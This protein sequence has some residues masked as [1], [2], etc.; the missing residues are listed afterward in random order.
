[1]VKAVI[2]LQILTSSAIGQVTLSEILSN[3]P[4]GR[5]RLEWIEVYNRSQTEIDLGAYILVVDSDTTI[6]DSGTYIS[7]ESFAVVARQP[8]PDNGSDS[9]ES[10]WGDSSGVWGDAPDEEYLLL[11]GAFTL[12]NSSGSV[13]LLDTAGIIID[14][15]N[16]DLVS[17]DGRSVEK[18][19]L[20]RDF[21]TWHNCYHPDGSTPGN[22]N[23]IVPA[24]GGQAFEI[25]IDPKIVSRSSGEGAFHIS[26]LIPSGTKVSVDI[27][28]DSGLKRTGLGDE[29]AS[30]VTQLDWAATDDLGHKL[31]PGVYI[32]DFSLTGQKN[33]HKSVPVV[34]A[35]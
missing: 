35:P 22:T 33:S 21:A 16:W 5:V 3:E 17:D 31:K 32:I 19:D 20:S 6:F 9:F 4:A 24:G 11:D 7:G 25:S 27:F 2:L 10:Y 1:M 23:S 14:Q 8:L 34:I 29:I 26:I 13:C 30:S 12:G 28:D 15:Y 18:D